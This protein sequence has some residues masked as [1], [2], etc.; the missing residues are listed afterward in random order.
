VAG[1]ALLMV[2]VSLLTPKPGAATIERYFPDRG[3]AVR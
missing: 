3:V 2:V 1:S